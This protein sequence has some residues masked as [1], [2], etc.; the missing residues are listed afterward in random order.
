[1]IHFILPTFIRKK[2]TD[3]PTLLWFANILFLFIFL[4]LAHTFLFR[5]AESVS[6]NEALW[7][8]WQ[9]FTTVGY[10]NAPAVTI[11]GR[12]VTA[13]IAT[14]GIALLGVLFAAALDIHLERKENR[15]KGLMKNPFQDGYV[16]FNFPGR[17]RAISLIRELRFTEPDV[18]ICFV[19]SSMEE[20]TPVIRSFPRIHFV[21]GSVLNEETYHHAALKENKCVIVFPAE[22]SVVESDAS[23]K[24]IVDLIE[25]FV[26]QSTRI[27][28]VLVD[29]A[30]EWMFR[31]SRS[32][33][34]I[35]SL[36]VLAVVQEC[37]DPY[38]ASALQKLLLNTEGTN[39]N[40][41][42]IEKLAD[43]SWESFLT[44][45]PAAA[46]ICGYQVTPFALVSDGDIITSPDYSRML[47]KGDQVIVFTD[48]R[49]KWDKFEQEVLHQISLST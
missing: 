28:H 6:W 23:T 25:Q 12:I 22:A 18:G 48:N 2:L 8:T 4:F 19:D 41:Y 9:T 30:N 34:I 3:N 29:P 10:G 46:R 27:L 16:V 17:S 43:I 1:M 13:V 49:L 39:P 44:S 7:Q 31:S 37:Q 35:E 45:T 38:S 33:A 47:A 11:Y 21:H 20:L 36:E 42:T 24:T 32:V 40:T 15:R 5:L 26:D 14:I